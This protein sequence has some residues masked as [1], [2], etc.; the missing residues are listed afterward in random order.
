M[1]ALALTAGWCAFSQPAA[2]DRGDGRPERRLPTPTP[3]GPVPVLGSVTAMPGN[4]CLMTPGVPN[5]KC[6][7]VQV[8]CP[9]LKP[10]LCDLDVTS[11]TTSPSTWR[12]TVVMGSGE[13]GHGF[14]GGQTGGKSIIERL[15]ALGFQV[16]DRSWEDTSGWTTNEAGNVVETCRYASM[17]TWVHANLHKVGKFVA[18]GNSGGSAEISYALSTWDRGGILDLALPTSGPPLGRL[19]YACAAPGTPQYTYWAAHCLDKVPTAQMQCPTGETCFLAPQADVCIQNPQ[20]GGRPTEA[21][22]LG[23][24][25]AHPGAAMSYPNLVHFLY[26]EQDC[27]EPVPIGLSYST[28]ITSKTIIGYVPN[29]PHELYST[30]EGQDAI[31]NAIDDG[32]K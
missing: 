18:T 8:S 6:Q 28:N 26:G 22:L 24:S 1:A 12:G 13:G 31:V 17:L 10:L 30:Q 2:L 29:T 11:P 32:T 4:T 19:D 27:A 20:W 3:S 25:V 23:D 15:V 14:Y 5:S 16:V 21:E 9:N 7:V